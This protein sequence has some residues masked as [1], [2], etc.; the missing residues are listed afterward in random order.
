MRYVLA[1]ATALLLAGSAQAATLVNGS[2]ELGISPGGYTT[3]AGGDSTSITGWTVGGGGVD[4]IGSYWIASDGVRSIDLSGGA[5]GSVSQ[6][7][8]TIAGRSYAVTFD[9]SANPDVGAGL[10]DLLVSAGAT[11]TL[12][13]VGQA[14]YPLT[15]TPTSFLFTALGSTS[16]LTFTSGANNSSW[17]PAID[18]V[19][20]SIVPVPEPATWIMLIAGFGL[21]G[22]AARRSKP[23]A[24]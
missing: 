7:F 20:A 15:W 22:V 21:V 14:G 5:P 8:A 24:A 17:G 6:T 4:Y 16:T 9:L 2:F 18:N 3:V 10:K 23:V 11:S 13:Q 19:A 1:T 12:Y